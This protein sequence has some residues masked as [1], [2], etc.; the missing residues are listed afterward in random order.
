MIVSILPIYVVGINYLS[1]ID[2]R[3]PNKLIIIGL[4]L[5]CVGVALIFRDNLKDIVNPE[6]LLGMIVCFSACLTWAIGSI[7]AKQKPSSSGVLTNAALQMFCGGVML[8]FMSP[9]LD[10]YSELQNVSVNSIWA[11]IYLIIFGS[12][13][14]YTSF[15]Y[16]L[17]KLPV[18]VASLYAYINPFIALLLG[19][20]WL[21]ESIT[22]L[23]VLALIT[24]LT[25][26]YCIN[27]GYQIQDPKL[28][29]Q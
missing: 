20:L 19:Y 16:A 10:N 2:K 29:K 21:E 15:V 23:T 25:G 14:A 5:G 26:V 9:F 18:G 6:Y 17:S 4:L 13:I 28:K 11:L 1:G 12:L 7:Y 24:A 22:Y 27:K 8:L 3:K